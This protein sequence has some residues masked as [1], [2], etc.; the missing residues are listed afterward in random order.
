MKKVNVAILGVTGAVGEVMLEI[1]ESRGFPIGEFYPLASERS[2]GETIRFNKKT[3]YILDAAE[4]DFSK[5]DI[6]FFSA[7]SS[8]SEQY[9]PIA[10][11]LGCVVIDNT[12]LFRRDPDVPL[13]IPEVNPEAIADY[14]VKNI[15]A[16]PNCSTI[17]MLVALYPLH[18]VAKI[19]RINVATY[20]S[21]SG[22]GRSAVNELSH[23][24]IELL[25]GR[26]AKPE[27]F[28]RSIA[29]NVIPHIDD[30][31]ENGFTKE[32]MKMIWETKKIF[33]DSEIGVNP[34]CVRVPVFYGH[35]EAIHIETER[36][37]SVA[38]ARK[39]LQSA[40]GVRVVDNPAKNDYP[41]PLSE[42]TG[43]DDVLVGRLREDLSIENG[44]NLWVVADNVRKGAA[45]NSIQ[46]AEILVRD[47]L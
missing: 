26:K 33:N 35:S 46:I 30:F 44:L 34:T 1:L 7:G 27:V 2:A 47:Y 37:L 36:K 40:P 39:I 4:F 16:N 8:V 42:A 15:I 18:Q 43:E 12:S 17:Q 9:V 32:E 31:E 5:A 14:A 28:S 11:S 22:K 6:A 45:L 13:V 23:Q 10:T 29:F 20:Q 24:T 19:K 38:E 21:V 41:C 3:Y 25:N